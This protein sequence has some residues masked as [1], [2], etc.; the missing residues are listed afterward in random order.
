MRDELAADLFDSRPT[1]LKTEENC[2][3]A[4]T[5]PRITALVVGAALVLV[6]MAFALSRP[7]AGATR[8]PHAA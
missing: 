6:G 1:H 4:I 2:G 5:T 8:A 7:P 3:I